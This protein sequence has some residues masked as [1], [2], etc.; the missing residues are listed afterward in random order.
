MYLQNE[1]WKK[2]LPLL[3]SFFIPLIITIIVCIDHGVY[4]FGE[5]CILHVDMYHQ[6]CPFFTEMM[7]KLKDGGS[8]LYSWNIGLGSDF[9]SLYAYYLA[10]PMNWLLLICPKNHVIEFMT[11]LIMLKIALCGLTF[12]YYLREHFEKNHFAISMFASAYALSAF[13]AAYSW[14]IMWMDCIFL[15]PLIILGLERLVKQGKCILYTIALACSI[16]TNYY[17]SIMICIFLVLYFVILWLE[18]KENRGKSI[19]HFAG[20]SLLAGGMGAVLLLPEM[21]ILS[22]SGSSGITFPEKMEWYFNIIAELARSC[23]ITAPYTGRDHW[24]NIYCGVFMLL[25]IVLYVLN[26]KISWK[27]K[28]SRLLF[29]AFFVLSFANNMLDF[30]WHGFHFPDSLPGRQSFL[31]IFLLLCIG[32]ETFLHLRGNHVIHV[33][34]AVVLSMALLLVGKI[35][36]DE[37]LVDGDAFI[38]TAVLIGCYAVVFVFYLAGTKPVKKGMLRLSCVIVLVELTLNFDLTGFDTTSRTAYVEAMSDYQTVLA[39]AEMLEGQDNITNFY[40]TEELERKTKNDAALFGYKSG[41]QFSSLMNINVSRF[42]RKLG[43]EGGKNFYCINGATPLSAAML[44]LKYVIADNGRE[45][46]PLRT[47]VSQS[48]ETHLYENKYVL[49]L[50]F[51]MSEDVIDAWDYKNGNEIT[52]QNELAF[53]LGAKDDMLQKMDADSI[54]TENGIT[55]IEVNQTGYL[56]ATYDNKAVDNMTEQTSDGRT[57]SFTKCSHG[58]TL[59]LGYCKAGT[60]V[61]VTNEDEAFILMDAYVLNEASVDAAF[62]TLNR[63]TM[64]LETF[65]DTRVTGTIDVTEAGRLIFSIPDEDGWTLLVD[66]EE[67][68]AEDFGDTFISV[69]LEKGTHEICL[70]YKTPGLIKGAA[71]SIACLGIFLGV[72]YWE[73]KRK[74]ERNLVVNEEEVCE[75]RDPLL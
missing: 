12:G 40:R 30:I 25:F 27:K 49:P 3:A 21:E 35:V 15:A 17:I 70:K 56:Y 23:A 37:S 2:R 69:H 61:S 39:E 6:Y 14:D 29:L 59:D 46:G 75:Y 22:Y 68:E 52:V 73:R 50:G 44:S 1:K 19:L 60:T 13:V 64:E 45:D 71:I 53:L 31:Y 20:C 63:Q 24:P 11:I 42:Y 10:S 28:V 66:G 41:T 74:N 55:T 48:G 5:E 47:L 7:N 65:S 58:Y 32:Y 62:E 9:V 26:R 51:M 4:P 67:V 38:M 54:T 18:N 16:L 43:M 33:G 8:L 57:K 72:T 34:I 36:S